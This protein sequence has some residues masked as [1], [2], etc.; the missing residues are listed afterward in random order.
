MLNVFRSHARGKKKRHSWR[1]C[2]EEPLELPRCSECHRRVGDRRCESCEADLCDSCQAFTHA[3]VRENARTCFLRG[4][5]VQHRKKTGVWPHTNGGGAPYTSDV[6][7]LGNLPNRT[8]DT[9]KPLARR[10]P[11]LHIE[12][13]FGPCVLCAAG[14]LMSRH[15]LAPRKKV[16]RAPQQLAARIAGSARPRELR[17]AGPSD[18]GVVTRRSRSDRRGRRTKYLPPS[19]LKGPR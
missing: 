18:V 1:T 14:R 9:T 16:V 12:W 5:L 17:L 7:P 10:A 6:P 11:E 2:L 8:S 19:P 4:L 13:A 15:A 3:K